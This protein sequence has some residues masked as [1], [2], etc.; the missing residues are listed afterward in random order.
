MSS[1]LIPLPTAAEN[2]QEFNA[3]AFEEMGGCTVILEKDLN[4]KI[5]NKK[6][7]EMLKMNKKIE[8]AVTEN[9]D[10]KIFRMIQPFLEK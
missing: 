4:E 9:A 1:I 2:H 8:K 5:L 6:I 7:E 10:E 3:R